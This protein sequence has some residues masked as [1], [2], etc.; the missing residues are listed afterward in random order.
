MSAKTKAVSLEQRRSELIAERDRC[1]KE[2]SSLRAR[3]SDAV[4]D[5]HSDQADQAESELAA[6]LTKRMRIE[7]GLARLAERIAEACA[8]RAEQ[9]RAKHNDEMARL[10]DVLAPKL[11]AFEAAATALGALGAEIGRD[12]EAIHRL[13]AGYLTMEDAVLHRLRTS[14]HGFVGIAIDLPLGREVPLFV[15]S[16][17]GRRE[18][19]ATYSPGKVVEEA[20]K[21]YLIRDLAQPSEAA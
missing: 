1:D 10:I 21:S 9:E 4:I 8:E 19:L 7:D 11:A 18:W 14:L 16:E 20:R 3:R 6:L 2:I 15:A 12:V 17:I 5:G 13:G